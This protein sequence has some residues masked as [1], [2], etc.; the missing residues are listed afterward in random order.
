MKTVVFTFGRMNPP[1]IGHSRVITK[2]VETAKSLNADHIVFLSQT[3]N[4]PN[5]PLSWDFKRRVC[6]A[7][8][9]GV[10]ISKDTSITNPFIALESL[11]QKY[12]KVVMVVGSDQLTEFKNNFAPYAKK[13]DTIF[14]VKSAGKRLDEA[15]GVEGISATKMRQYA[16]ENNYAKF[17]EG[18]PSTLNEGICKLVFSNTRKGI[19]K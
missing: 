18:L 6:E 13:W 4:A 3:H 16:L 19:K 15:E 1:T 8:F 5:N 9:K 17:K 11:A 12:E 7:A 14:E 10:N 2:I